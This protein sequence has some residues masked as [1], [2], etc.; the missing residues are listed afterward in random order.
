M[1]TLLNDSTGGDRLPALFES[2]P[3][4]TSALAINANNAV[5]GNTISSED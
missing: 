5:I 2:I 1:S 3:G 4:L